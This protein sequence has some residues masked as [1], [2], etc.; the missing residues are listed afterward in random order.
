MDNEEYRGTEEQKKELEEWDK[1]LFDCQ[2]DPPHSESMEDQLTTKPDAEMQAEMLMDIQDVE[3]EKEKIAL[4]YWFPD[5]LLEERGEEEIE[6]IREFTAEE[7]NN[8]LNLH[9]DLD[10]LYE[11]ETEHTTKNGMTYTKKTVKPPMNFECKGNEAP[12]EEYIAKVTGNPPKWSIRVLKRFTD[13]GIW[14]GQTA[15]ISVPQLKNQLP[16]KVKPSFAESDKLV[17]QS[18]GLNKKSTVEFTPQP[19]TSGMLGSARNQRQ[20]QKQPSLRVQVLH[21]LAN[22][23]HQHPNLDMR[24]G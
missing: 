3:D 22:N 21:K 13:V 7:A 12:T 20:K 4:D 9:K 5:D 2:E 6:D 15:G 11:I 24:V 17:R 16:D 14:D 23:L 1:L 10:E 8:L 19:T 18:S